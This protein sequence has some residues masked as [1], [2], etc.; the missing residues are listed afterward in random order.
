MPLHQRKKDIV[1]TP[2]RKGTA[3]YRFDELFSNNTESTLISLNEGSFFFKSFVLVLSFFL[4]PFLGVWGALS[5]SRFIFFV[6]RF[7]GVEKVYLSRS[8][9][10]LA[11]LLCKRIEFILH[12]IECLYYFEECESES[13]LFK[14]ILY[15]HQAI[16]LMIFEFSL[17]RSNLHHC[18]SRTECRF[19]RLKGIES[20]FSKNYLFSKEI[21]D[22]SKSSDVGNVP[23][24]FFGSYDNVRNITLAKEVKLQFPDVMLFGRNGHLLPKELASN[25]FG[26]VHN[27]EL[28]VTRYVL[29]LLSAP[30]AGIQTKVIDWIECGG[31]VD[32]PKK[33]YLRMGL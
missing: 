31:R 10:F 22:V 17:S 20:F 26:E 24:C 23:R 25:Y 32:V 28:F 7:R 4:T 18:L 29:T 13:N 21:D 5:F 12:N 16:L 11:P 8:L 33:L 14:K 30:R 3:G 15:F 19:L 27:L 9:V 1:L 6:S 2:H